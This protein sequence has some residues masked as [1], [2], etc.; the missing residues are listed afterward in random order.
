GPLQGPRRARRKGRNRSILL[1]GGF[2]R[3]ASSGDDVPTKPKCSA[4]TV[5][6]APDFRFTSGQRPC[7]GVMQPAWGSGGDHEMV[8]AFRA[9]LAYGED[10][11]RRPSGRRTADLRSAGAEFPVPVRVERHQGYTRWY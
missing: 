11:T 3:C 9:G 7:A 2:P 5:L 6:G 1:G 8:T 10:K 4:R